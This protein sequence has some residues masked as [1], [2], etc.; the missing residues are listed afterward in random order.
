MPR[1]SSLVGSD[2]SSTSASASASGSRI[3]VTSVATTPIS[4]N[5]DNLIGSNIGKAPERVTIRSKE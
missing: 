2:R 5:K 1:R 4:F 3:L